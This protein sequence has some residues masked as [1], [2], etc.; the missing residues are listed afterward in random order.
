MIK[1]RYIVL[2]VN[3]NSFGSLSHNKKRSFL[4]HEMVYQKNDRYFKNYERAAE[5]ARLLNRKGGQYKKFEGQL[6]TWVPYYER[7]Y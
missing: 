1:Y 4:S 7:I 5:Y 3:V 2:L 6:V